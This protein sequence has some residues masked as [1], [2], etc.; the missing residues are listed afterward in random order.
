MGCSLS[1]VPMTSNRR[2][3]TPKQKRIKDLTAVLIKRTKRQSQQ[4][5]ADKLGIDRSRVARWAN[6]SSSTELP[7]LEIMAR[8]MGCTTPD[9]ESYVNGKISL[10][11]FLEILY[12]T[13]ALSK[14]IF[15]SEI[16]PQSNLAGILYSLP[17]LPISDLA[18]IIERIAP[19]IKNYNQNTEKS[20][21]LHLTCA[22]LIANELER[23]GWRLSDEGLA[24][25]ADLA[26]LD[27]SRLRRIW[28][29]LAPTEEDLIA[30]SRV[31]RHPD[32]ESTWTVKELISLSELKTTV[33]IND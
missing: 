16:Q 23:R 30:L 6:G 32:S 12:P 9:L 24:K 26:F 13:P 29:G 20:Q 1:N 17:F 31:L 2:S 28:Y 22:V 19:M 11:E 8:S 15:A 7:A 5:L 18:K 3:P 10:S 14:S 27:V 33:Y 25:L 21:S 4:A